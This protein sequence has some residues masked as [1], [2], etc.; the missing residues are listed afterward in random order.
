MI[1]FQ[2]NRNKKYK[3]K[4]NELLKENDKKLR[5]IEYRIDYIKFNN[6][7]CLLD[8]R[9]VDRF[10]KNIRSKKIYFDHIDD[11]YH[12]DEVF[13]NNTTKRLKTLN[14]SIA[15]KK[16]Q[17]MHGE[18]IKNNL[19]T[20]GGVPWNKG[21][22]TGIY[23]WNKGKTK[24]NDDRLMKISL[25]RI[26]DGNPMFGKSPTQEAREKQSKKIKEKILSGE[27]TPNIHN[28]NTHWQVK[29]NNRKYRSSWEAFFHYFN[30][31]YHYEKLR[32]SYN[33][34]GKN[35]I[36]IVDFVNYETNHIVEIKPFI[37]IN[38][39]KEIQKMK[40]LQQYCIDN[41]FK[42]DILSEDYIYTNFNKL[43][44][45]IF[46]EITYNNIRKSYETYKKNIN[47]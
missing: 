30:P 14:A 2:S 12:F 25:D 27:F 22:K 41:G 31:E 1:N 6:G 28:S 15:A 39:E 13:R 11:V 16:C 23:P 24:I 10:K 44:V 43:P 9:S 7:H 37:Y 45:D 21:I 47:R 4:I 3:D 38:T 36:Y 34:K 26:G 40:Y 19:N 17:K 46:D 8:E 32:I 20:I 42:Y 5:V 29:Y 35:K 18:K 33:L